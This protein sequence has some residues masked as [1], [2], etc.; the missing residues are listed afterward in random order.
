MAE[1]GRWLGLGIGNLI[2]L[3]NPEV[4]VLGGLYHRFYQF[5]AAAVVQGARSQ[6]LAA[7]WS[8]VTIVPSGLGG[9]AALMGAA[10][11]AL[12]PTMADPAGAGRAPVFR[13]ERSPRPAP[14]LPSTIGPL[15]PSAR[16]RRMLLVGAV[17]GVT[18]VL[19]LFFMFDP[20][21]T[22]EPALHPGPR[23]PRAGPWP[24]SGTRRCSTPSARDVPMP[25]VH[26]RN[27]LSAAMWDAWAAYSPD[28]AGYFVDE[29]H[30]AADVAAARDEAISYAAYRILESRYM[31]SAAAPDSIPEFDALMA[32]L[33]YPADVTTTEGDS[34]AAVGNRIAAAILAFGLTDGSNQQGG[35]QPTGYRPVN[36]PLVVKESGTVMADP[37]RWQPLEIDNMVTQNGILLASGPQKAIGP[38]WGH[39]AGF[40]LPDGGEDGL[41]LDPGTPP[42]LGDSE[43]DQ[44]FKDSAVDVIRQQP[45]GPGGWRTHRHLARRPWQPRSAPTTATVARLIP[46]PASPTRRTSSNAADFARVL[47]E[48][49]ADGPSSETPPGHWNALANKVTDTPPDPAENRR[50]RAAP[51]PA[52][53]GCETLPGPQRRAARR[54]HLRL[55]LQAGLQFLPPHQRHPSPGRARDNRPTPA[56]LPTIRKDFRSSPA[57]SS[58]SPPPPPR[59]ASATPTSPPTSG[60]SPSA[61]GPR[62]SCAPGVHWIRAVGLAALSEHHLRHPGVSRFCLRSQHLQPRRRRGP[63]ALHRQRVFPRRSRHLHRRP[64]DFLKTDTGPST[65]VVL[66]WATYYD[67]ADQAGLSRIYGGIHVP[68]DD[69]RPRHRERRSG[70]PPGPKRRPASTESTMPSSRRRGLLWLAAGFA[71][72]GLVTLGFVLGGVGPLR[73]GQPRPVRPGCAAP[74][75]GD[76]RRRPRPRLRRRVPVLRRRRCRRLRL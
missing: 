6:A 63:G 55:G 41:P 67:A 65:D 7:P 1:V 31:N 60:K 10:E 20:G 21:G 72:G 57:P 53:V 58:S 50:Q 13:G 34:P 59:P 35:Y 37:N 76:G 25:T 45:D 49:W 64:N 16:S 43:S 62:K 44:E 19:V 47:A 30:T 36:D 12:T 23:A 32:A 42:R 61:P 8:R 26:A 4:V 56:L 27:L 22:G 54:R 66:Q 29:K 51:R 14:G 68:A 28:A 71:G 69:D 18:V 75:R 5:L 46:P 17:L 52:G 24:A 38:H 33:C 15:M 70:G 11:L 48:Y 73:G 74:R 3:F 40:A 2:N 39:V 9:D